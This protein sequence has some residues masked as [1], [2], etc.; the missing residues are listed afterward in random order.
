[1]NH[2]DPPTSRVRNENGYRGCPLTSTCIP[3]H[4]MCVHTHTHSNN[5]DGGGGGDD[6]ENS[7]NKNYDNNR[8][9]K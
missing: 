5:D 8:G 2:R 9:D 4:G 1:M 7:N 3:C 6:D